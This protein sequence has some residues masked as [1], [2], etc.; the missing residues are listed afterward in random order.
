M[1]GKVDIGVLGAQFSV[2]EI[3]RITDMQRKR[4]DLAKNDE[5]VLLD[6]IRALKEEKNNASS[7]DEL[8]D[9]LKIIQ[10][11]KKKQ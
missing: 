4:A 3:A 2:D 5:T 10:S 8:E 6:S 9:A 7:G 1:R 11:K